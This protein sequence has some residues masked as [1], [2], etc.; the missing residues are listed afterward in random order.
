MIK[1]TNPERRIVEDRENETFQIKLLKRN[2][3]KYEHMSKMR[4]WYVG[5]PGDMMAEAIL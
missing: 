1:V 3:R 5:V 4:I 2:R